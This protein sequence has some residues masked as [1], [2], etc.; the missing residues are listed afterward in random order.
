MVS[1]F[2]DERG[3]L[4]ISWVKWGIRG[5]LGFCWEDG[6]TETKN[7]FKTFCINSKPQRHKKKGRKV[8]Q[9]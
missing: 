2:C 1:W 3:S 6:G 8:E 9:R 7:S 5:Y 4:G